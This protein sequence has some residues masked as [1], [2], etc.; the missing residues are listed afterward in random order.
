MRRAERNMEKLRRR[1]ADVRNLNRMDGDMVE[2]MRMI[3]SARKLR[4][5]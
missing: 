4:R 1:I 2:V 3:R 5:K